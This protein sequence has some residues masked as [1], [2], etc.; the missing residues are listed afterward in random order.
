M[1]FSRLPVGL[2]MG[3]DCTIWWTLRC[4][5]WMIFVF[6]Y[7][8]TWLHDVF[9][10]YLGISLCSFFMMRLQV[11]SLFKKKIY[12]PCW[13]SIFISILFNPTQHI[14]LF[15]IRFVS[16][17]L[18]TDL[19]YHKLRSNWFFFFFFFDRPVLALARGRCTAKCTHT[20]VSDRVFLRC[21]EDS[22]SFLPLFYWFNSLVGHAIFNNCLSSITWTHRV[23][24][25]RPCIAN[26]LSRLILKSP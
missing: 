7:L 15:S 3:H 18:V 26:I 6:N 11:C 9:Y 25:G 13:H 16:F 14:S 2:V 8:N 23:R 24:L 10:H 21:K 1:I 19:C 17:I 5:V 22:F 20:S 12:T 4:L